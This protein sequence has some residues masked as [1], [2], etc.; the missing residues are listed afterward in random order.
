[1]PTP[2]PSTGWEVAADPYPKLWARRGD[3]PLISATEGEEE[4]LVAADVASPLVSPAAAAAGIVNEGIL[5]GGVEALTVM[6]ELETVVEVEVEVVV[7]EAVDVVVE[8]VEVVGEVGAV[9]VFVVDVD[10]DEGVVEEGVE[11]GEVCGVE[12]CG[13]A[14]CGMVA[15]CER[16]GTSFRL[17]AVADEDGVERRGTSPPLRPDSSKRVGP[18]CIRIARARDTRG[19]SSFM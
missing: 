2:V 5:K 15:V 16:G 18:S 19:M 12:I 13:F 7:D 11:G 9:L 14:V 17:V 1:V 8:G 10:D 4:A 3:V 6:D